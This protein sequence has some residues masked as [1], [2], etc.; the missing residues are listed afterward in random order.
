[1]NILDNHEIITYKIGDIDKY[2]PTHK[3]YSKTKV[4]YVNGLI[5]NPFDNQPSVWIYFNLYDDEPYDTYLHHVQYYNNGNIE[6]KGHKPD[7]ITYYSDGKVKEC[8]KFVERFYFIKG[9]MDCEEI[10]ENYDMLESKREQCDLENCD[11]ICSHWYDTLSVRCNK[12]YEYYHVTS[13]GPN[14]TCETFEQA[15]KSKHICDCHIGKSN[16]LKI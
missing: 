8:S 11:I 4:S 9:Y 13:F 1:M 5:H 2:E 14:L 10:D 12:C 16:S 6:R 7:Q 3:F 15:F